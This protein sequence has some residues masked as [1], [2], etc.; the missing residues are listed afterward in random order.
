[1]DSYEKI[2][3]R[4]VE[5]YEL[6][7]GSTIN[8]ESDIMLRL[9]VLSAEIYNN[10]VAQE[11]VKRQMFVQ[12]ATGKYLDKHA[13]QRGLKR[14]EAVKAK[15]EVTFYLEQATDSD[16]VIKKS[17]AVATVGPD[18]KSFV[19]DS[20]ATIVAGQKSVK[21][22]VTAVQGGSDYNVAENTVTVMVTPPLGTSGVKNEKAFKGGFDTET[23]DELR[24]R[25]LDSYKDIS[26]AT[27]AVY[28]KRLVKSVD[29]IHSASVVPCSRG[30]GTVDI[31]VCGYKGESVKREQIEQA[32]ALIDENRELNLDVFVL[33]ALQ[34]KVYF[35]FT[36]ECVDGYDFDE[37]S[38]LLKEKITNYV[39][40][41]EVAQPV[42]LSDIGNII[43]NTQGVKNY[44]FVDAY[45]NDVY[46]KSNEKCIVENINIRAVQ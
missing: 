35:E 14:K 17:T 6:Y 18:A 16:I 33:Y 36:L 40:A 29:G 24:T 37:L 9:R 41:L 30:A 4:M 12:T 1:M 25:V 45:C 43:Y 46:P 10:Y 34:N 13:T 42:L 22:G 26:N 23:D 44:S 15:G 39:N 11:F 38:V 28:Y 21:V 8:E 19:T 31:Y 20:D 2:L 32:Q 5:D 3:S 27:N 7:S